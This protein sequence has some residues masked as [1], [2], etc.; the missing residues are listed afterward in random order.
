LAFFRDALAGIRALPGVGQ[1]SAVSDLPLSGTEEIDQFT[2]EGRPAPPSLNDTPLADF[3]FIDHD[4]FT[5]MGTPLKAGRYFTEHDNENAPGVV[6]I[7]ES[8]A[9]RF[10]PDEDPIGKRIRPGDAESQAA[11]LPVVGVVA[12]VKHSGL[13][14]D[15]RPQLYF[16]YAQKLWGQMTIIARTNVDP[17]SLIPAMREAV[18]AIDKDQPITKIKTMEHYLAASVSQRRFNLIMLAAFSVIAL[19]LAGVG[20]YGVMSY[21]VTQRTHEIGIRMALGAQSSNV[22]GMVVRQGLKL[23]AAGVSIGLVGAILLT[24]LMSSLLYG[25]SVTDPVTY[26]VISVILTGVALV[27]CLVPARRATKVD[28]MVALRYE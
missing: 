28:P 7:S 4:Y 2:V 20:L 1:V 27:A 6:I 24:R 11:W 13:E 5:A 25:V 16:P 12:S 23:I 9:R 10:F 8:L 14:A 22:L 21:S 26:V 15:P 17:E 18:W 19:I 3:R